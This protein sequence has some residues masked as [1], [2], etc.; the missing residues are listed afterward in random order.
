M[1]EVRIPNGYTGIPLQRLLCRIVF[2]GGLQNPAAAA[3]VHGFACIVVPLFLRKS[4]IFG[5]CVVFC[6]MHALHIPN[7]C[8]TYIWMCA[9]RSFGARRARDESR[10]NSRICQLGFD[11]QL[12]P[13]R[14]H[15]C[16]LVPGSP[17]DRE[18]A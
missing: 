5:G 1:D 13:G 11:F 2:F 7:I 8:A 16:R 12:S 10:G 4:A 14:P 15:K 6:G 17:M 3:A 9:V 18:V